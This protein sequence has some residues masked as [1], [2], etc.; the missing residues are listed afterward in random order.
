[1]GTVSISI[2]LPFWKILHFRNGKKIG[3]S[4]VTCFK[5][6]AHYDP[7]GK[8]VGKSIR[9]IMGDLNHY[10]CQGHSIGYSSK[11]GSQVITR[12]INPGH[13]KRISHRLFGIIYIHTETKGKSSVNKSFS[14]L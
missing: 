5:G 4:K 11:N 1:M 12:Y 6:L 8:V 14:L 9:N 2:K 3:E 10:D 13:K 7:F